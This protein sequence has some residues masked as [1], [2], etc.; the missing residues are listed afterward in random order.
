MSTDIER[1]IDEYILKH[2]YRQ[3]NSVLLCRDDEILASCYYN[4]FHKDS[5]NVIMSV[6]KSIMSICAGIALDQGLIQSIDEPIYKYIHEFSEGRD[7]FHRMI[8]I[9]HLL[10]MT[11]GICWNGGVHYHCPMMQQLRNS[12]DWISHIAD[13]AVVD[14]PGTKY[15]YKEWDVILLAKLLDQ[16]CGDMYDFI[17]DNLFVPL[18]IKG[19]RWYK[20]PCGVYYSVGNDEEADNET[21]FKMTAFDML[22]IGLI[23][24]NGGRYGEE[25]ILSEDYI[26]QAVSPLKCNPNYGFLWWILDEGYGCRG[27]GGQTITVIPNENAVIVTQAT[28]TSRGLGYTDVVAYCRELLRG[29]VV[30]VQTGH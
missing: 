20:S 4:G 19:E 1:Q 13:C 9:R 26:H 2:H 3:M 17:N 28:P 7:S 22:K 21:K 6:A 12:G 11:S 15:N 30:T 29:T 25:Q 23:F 18:Q 10:T 27:Y 14:I 16:V 8:T 24:L 5:K